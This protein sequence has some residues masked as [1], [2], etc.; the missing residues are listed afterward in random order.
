MTSYFRNDL[1][2]AHEDADQ[3]VEL[4]ARIGHL[5]AET[6]A[7]DI[8]FYVL[9]AWADWLAAREQAERGLELAR[10]LGAQRFETDFRLNLALVLGAEGERAAAERHLDEA[11]AF[12]REASLA[13][14]G[15]WILGALA[16]ATDDTDKRR[17]ALAEGEA[18]LAAGSISHNHLN[19]Y[20][21]AIDVALEDA[22]WQAVARYC[23]ALEDYTRPEPLPWSDF[24]IAR[25]RALAA[26]K[27][28]RHGAST[29]Q[30]LQR[31]ADEAERVGLRVALL[32]LKAAL[33]EN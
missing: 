30:E 21:L 1:Q 16:S 9:Y 23:A 4:A 25:G 17:W 2:A 32:A 31:L 29:R 13:F 33:A 3:A 28:G 20:Q 5:R 26:W 24:F 19:F 10:R 15:P 12:S 11:Y 6:L 22:D 7:R 14:A 27:S 18:L 8:L